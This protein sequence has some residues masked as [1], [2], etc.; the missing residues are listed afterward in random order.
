MTIP[1]VSYVV[2][3]D[4]HG[5]LAEMRLALEPAAGQPGK[6]GGLVF[7]I[8]PY[9]VGPYAEGAYQIVLPLSAF[10]GL[11]NPPY[12]GDFSGAPV[13]TGDVTPRQG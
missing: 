9:A 1:E 12:A 3:D 11:L 4:G 7:L 5:H 10:Q 13:R 2:P 8:G 6:A